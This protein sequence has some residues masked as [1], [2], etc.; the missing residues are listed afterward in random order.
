MKNMV[1]DV[2]N[3]HSTGQRVLL[4]QVMQQKSH[5][6]IAIVKNEDEQPLGM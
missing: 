6:E 1:Q 3:I 2:N 5:C 4:L